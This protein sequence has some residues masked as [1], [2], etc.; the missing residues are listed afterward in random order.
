MDPKLALGGRVRSGNGA[1]LLV[2]ELW[3]SCPVA[4][5]FLS[6]PA[7]NYYSVACVTDQD[8]AD[9]PTKGGYDPPPFSMDGRTGSRYGGFVQRPCCMVLAASR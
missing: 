4:S 5:V 1:F 9:W 8:S 3:S 6:T 2:S 7:R